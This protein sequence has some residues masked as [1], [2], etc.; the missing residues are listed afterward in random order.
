M[1]DFSWVTFVVTLLNIGILYFILRAILFKPVTQFM[2]KRTKKIAGDIEQV[3]QDKNRAKALLRQYEDTLNQAR[4]EADR[5]IKNA[6][7]SAREQADGIVAQ[8]KVQA[9]AIIANA[10]QQIEAEREAAMVKFKAE[11]AALVLSAASRL[12]R[13]ELTQEDSRNQA[14]L[15]LR[16]LGKTS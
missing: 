6:R 3:E 16:E 15:L 8:G 10:R 11:A 13:R 5:I 9:E 2:E 14:A 4:D 1:L 12:L 7:E